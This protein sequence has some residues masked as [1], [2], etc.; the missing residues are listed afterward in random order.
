MGDGPLDAVAIEEFLKY[1]T[2]LRV[3]GILS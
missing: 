1:V 2:R 3:E